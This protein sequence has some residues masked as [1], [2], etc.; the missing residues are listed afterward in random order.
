MHTFLDAVAFNWLTVGT[1]AHARNYAL[2]HHGQATRLAPLY[3][4]NSFL[5]Y[6]SE[7]PSP[8]AM[9]IGF[10]QSDPAQVSRS[11]WGELARDCRVDEESLIERVRLVAERLLSNADAVLLAD[12]AAQWG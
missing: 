9:R 11:D 2:L 1:D 8:L 7:H 10:T 5:P 6:A 12:D 4:M 3:D